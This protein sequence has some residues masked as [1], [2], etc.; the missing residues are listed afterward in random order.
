MNALRTSLAAIVSDAGVTYWYTPG[1]VVRVGWWTPK[2]LQTAIS[3]PIYALRVGDETYSENSSG[4]ALGEVKVGIEVFLLVAKL[5][6]EADNPHSQPT[7][8]REQV[9][10]RMCADVIRKL[11]VDV[12]LLSVTDL[13]AA[14]GS[15]ENVFDEGLVVDR[16]RV[17]AGWA[18]AEIRFVVGYRFTAGAP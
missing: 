14:G 6:T 2:L 15:V 7:I 8:T 5:F 13:A 9:V 10:S 12:Q 16:D 17:E 1:A 18:L 4:D 3:G 11:L